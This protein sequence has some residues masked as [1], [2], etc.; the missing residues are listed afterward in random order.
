MG[1][2]RGTSVLEL[3]A[4]FEAASGVEIQKQIQGRRA[5]D[6]ATSMAVPDKANEIL[7]WKTELTIQDACRD[8]W[9]WCKKNP[10][11][12]SGGLKE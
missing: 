10:N 5:G 1:T 11:G 9:N 7:N 8:N 2:G 4:A 12:Y 3:V 6:A